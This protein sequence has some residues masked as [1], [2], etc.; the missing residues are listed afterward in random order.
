MKYPWEKAVIDHKANG[1]DVKQTHSGQK[2]R[3]GDSFYEF[4]VK[5]NKPES[6]VQKYCNDTVRKCS[7]K[8]CDYL[9]N[10]RIKGRPFDDH[11]RPSYEF[12]KVVDGEYFYRVTSPSCD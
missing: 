11:F 5:S 3:Y 10:E 7:L 8:T 4:T 2:R 1:F 9:A 6:E 12:K